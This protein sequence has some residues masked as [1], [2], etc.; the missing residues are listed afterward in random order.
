MPRT[1]L[2]IVLLTVALTACSG[3]AASAT[4]T[5][6]EPVVET[7]PAP[8]TT[9]AA[10]AT[11][12]PAP[13]A[14]DAVAAGEEAP[15]DDKNPALLDPSLA[16]KTAPD[17]YTVKFETTKGDI[18]IDVDRSW[19]PI[20]A[21]RFYNLVDVG[22]YDDVAM[23]RV[24]DGFMAQMGIHG[25]PAVNRVWRNARIDDDPVSKSNTAG[26]VTFATAGPNTRTTQVFMNFGDNSNLDSM[27]FA[28]FGKLRDM[29]TLNTIYSGYGE[30]APRGR[31]PHQGQFQSG[32]NAY[33]KASFPKLDYI[34]KATIVTE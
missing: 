33:L 19:A 21:D 1:L 3:D 31:G 32:G 26:M 12:A 17:K 5:A 34:K 20:G 13:A 22:Y 27:G 10:V 23:F 6:E 18:L 14:E 15:K 2:P 24:I 25:D 11:P 9:P 29:E 16:N 7:T 4:E 8:V 28:P 30:G